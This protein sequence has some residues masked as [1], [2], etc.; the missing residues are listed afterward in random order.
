M[1]T[2]PPTDSVLQM[3]SFIAV[4][5]QSMTA[6]L[7]AGRRSMDWA[8]VCMLG[9]ITALGGGTIRD[10][11]LGHY[12]LLWV[13][14]P[15][16]LAIAAAGAFATILLARL[17][18]RLNLAF[19]VLDAIGLVV[20][21]M[22][23]CD[24]AWQV[25]ASLPI[26]IVAGMITGCAGGVLRDILCNEVPLLFRSEL[27]A[28]VSVVTGLF[29]ATAFGLNLNPPAWTLL[30]F[31]LGLSFRLLAIRY[32]WEMPKFVFSGEER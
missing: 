11:L 19:L 6:A 24:V 17:V 21:T 8:G 25:D 28:S 30:T 5:A 18:H 22:A 12:P 29:Y 14:H 2:M 10:V 3:L 13:K 27:Y 4:A 7:A 1:W 26:V 31:A 32:K 9:A 16:Y 15:I 20:F 23:G